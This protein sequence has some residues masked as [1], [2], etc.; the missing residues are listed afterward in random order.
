MRNMQV[1]MWDL[2]GM[3]MKWMDEHAERIDLEELVSIDG[4][5]ENTIPIHLLTETDE[6]DWL[7]IFEYGMR[8]YVERVLEL[9]KIPKE[10]VM[11][12]FEILSLVEH[13]RDSYYMF[14]DEIRRA[15]EYYE[16]RSHQK[17]SIATVEE[18]V[19]YIGQATDLCIMYYMYTKK[20]NWAL[21][22]MKKFY[23]LS[24]RYYT[25]TENQKLFLDVGANI[26]TTCVYFKKRIDPEVKIIAL[27]PM[28]ETHWLLSQNIRING[29]ED[30]ARA[31]R[32]GV[33]DKAEERI[34]HYNE[35]N[36]G[37]S[38]FVWESGEGRE[39]NIRTDS[40]D[41]I[42]ETENINP[43][44]IKYIWVDVEGFEGA[45]VSGGKET[46]RRI[47]VPMVVEVTPKL[48]EAQGRMEQFCE[49]MEELYR[50]Y[51]VMGE[52]EIREYPIEKLKEFTSADRHDFQK[53]LFFLK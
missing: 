15:V 41:H 17:Y 25:F 42:V 38:S 52:E 21:D 39:V 18:D 11:Y 34:F 49:D 3:G 48:L 46:L 31:I 45:F 10:K 37:G 33:S 28:P 6:W 27:E 32:I 35:I 36:P 16:L 51:I 9:Q 30:E 23:E 22:D 12:P 4:K 8:P 5:K 13:G 14:D 47:C 1:V 29:C 20:Q 24:N 44:Q 43:Y 7:F 50:G 26:G 53:D 19:T 2:T 40:F